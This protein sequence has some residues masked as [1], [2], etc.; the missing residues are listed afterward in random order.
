MNGKW[1]RKKKEKNG[2]NGLMKQPY[3]LKPGTSRCRY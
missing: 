1:I 3:K 2:K